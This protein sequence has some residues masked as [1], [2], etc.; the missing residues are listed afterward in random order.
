[1]TYPFNLNDLE[2]T[3]EK[4]GHDG[5]AYDTGFEAEDG[6]VEILKGNKIKICKTGFVIIKA[7][8]NGKETWIRLDCVEN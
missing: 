4:S 3:I 1:M 8:L 2:L 6:I 7:T 5:P